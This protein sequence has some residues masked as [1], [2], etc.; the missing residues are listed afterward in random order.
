MSHTRGDAAAPGFPACDNSLAAEPEDT[1]PSPAPTVSPPP[2]GVAWAPA[3]QDAVGGAVIGNR[4]R[5][6]VPGTV[7]TRADVA[8]WS[9]LRSRGPAEPPRTGGPSGLSAREGAG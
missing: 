1:P 9:R 8:A 5:L 2:V 4:V 3:F 6:T 7:M